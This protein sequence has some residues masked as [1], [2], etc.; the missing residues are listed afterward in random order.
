MEKTEERKRERERERSIKM[1]R[2]RSGEQRETAE[3]EGE[4]K[5]RKDVGSHAGV[6]SGPVM[7]LADVDPRPRG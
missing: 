1:D 6:T 4:G 3:D 7:A 5:L 2:R